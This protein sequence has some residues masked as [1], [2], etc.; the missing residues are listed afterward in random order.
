VATGRAANVENC[1]LEAGQVSYE[2][3]TGIHIN[4]RAQSVS[5]PNIYAVGDCCANVPRLTHMSG[6]M[7]KLV[8]QNSLAHDPWQVSSLVVPAVTYTEPEYATVGIASIE[9]AQKVGID[10]DVYQTSLQ[11]NDRAIVESSTVGLVKILVQKDTD[12]IVGT[13]MV[14]ERAG[15]VINE[16]TLAMKN[17]LG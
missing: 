9:Q 2:V 6:E 17:N 8:V 1:G 10:C 7:A 4:D 13:T 14:A 11:H 16:V 3:G 5:N 12:V 15:E